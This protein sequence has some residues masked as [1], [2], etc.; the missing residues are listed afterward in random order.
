M[1]HDDALQDVLQTLKTN[2]ITL[3][4]DK[5]HLGKE[6]VKWFGN[7]YS[8]DGMSA[9]LE[10]CMIIRNWPPPSSS[11]EVKRFLQIVQFNAKFLGA[12][13]IGE[14]SYPELTKPL[15]ALTKKNAKF[16]WG[17]REINSFNEIKHQLC[18]DRVLAPYDTDRQTRL[19]VD[20]SPIGTQ[21]TLAQGYQIDR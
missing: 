21:A 8:K 2:V 20:S 13:K 12:H 7:I 6:E 16:L 1:T 4:L 19:Y 9:G 5:C 18:S 17:Q 14:K 11:T 3:Q 10:K 15:R